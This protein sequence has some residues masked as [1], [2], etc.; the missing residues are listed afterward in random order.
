MERYDG[1]RRGKEGSKERESKGR[2]EQ[3]KKERGMGGKL[4]EGW[5]MKGK[6]KGYRISRRKRGPQ[7]GEGHRDTHCSCQCC[8]HITN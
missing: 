6:A 2:G 3:E 5:M 1:K 8:Q 7:G 4:E